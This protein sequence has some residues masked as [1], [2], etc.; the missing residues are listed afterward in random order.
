M[1]S[2]RLGDSPKVAWLRHGGGGARTRVL[3]HSYESDCRHRASP[4]EVP[5]RSPCWRCL[6]PGVMET[7]VDRLRRASTPVMCHPWLFWGGYSGQC[8]GQTCGTGT[9][10]LTSVAVCR[11][12]PCERP[13]RL[14]PNSRR[15]SRLSTSRQA[16]KWAPKPESGSGQGGGSWTPVWV[17]LE[18]RLQGLLPGS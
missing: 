18:C 11:W 4:S 12:E 14:R 15:S 8:S 16:Q 10:K 3:S 1:V 5:A 13:S 6:M 9:Q 7:G 17:V 2:A